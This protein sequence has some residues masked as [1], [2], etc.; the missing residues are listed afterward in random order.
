[1]VDPPPFFNSYT[2]KLLA[3]NE[4]LFPQTL[5]ARRLLLGHWFGVNASDLVWPK[6]RLISLRGTGIAP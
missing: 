1:M 4:W 2:L 5:H 6:K 3:P